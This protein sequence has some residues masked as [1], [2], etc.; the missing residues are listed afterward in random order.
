MF[1]GEKAA[2][3]KTLDAASAIA[4]ADV[5]PP[6]KLKKGQS[7]IPSY[8]STKS[9]DRSQSLDKSDR[10]V[11]TTDIARLPRFQG[12]DDLLR[13]LAHVSPDLSASMFAYIRTAVTRSYRCIARN[14]DG[15]VNPEATSLAQQLLVRYD[16]LPDYEAGFGGSLTVRSISESWAKELWINGACAGELVL[17]DD[18]MP[19]RV[20][21]LTVTTIEFKPDKEGLA[22]VQVVGGDEINLD[23]PTFFYTALD[24][25]LM[26]AYP[27]SPVE[28]ALRATFFSEQFIA[29]VQRV[30][31]RAIHPRMMVE[32]DYDAFLKHMPPEAQ[33]DP[34]EAE[35]YYAKTVSDI[36]DHINGLEPEDA[37]VY[38]NLIKIT[39]EVSGNISLARE[40]ETLE[41]LSNAKMATGAKVLPSVL[42]HN[43]GSSNI[44]ST[45][46][47]LFMKY[48]EGAIQF[49]L[50]EMWSKIM[51]LSCRLFGLDVYV[52]FKFDTIDLRPESELEAFKQ[53][54]Q[55]R[56]LELLS[57]GL[58]PDEEVA[59]ELTGNL[60]PEGHKPLSGTMFKS[61]KA[62]GENLYGGQTNKGSTLN[63]NLSP[64]TP[65]Q[66]RGENTK[67]NP[68]KE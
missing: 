28:S 67:S 22:P 40:Y 63:K 60:P 37:L 27:S 9:A 43:A 20:Q 30:V 15:T 1:G 57:L 46:T 10:R 25:E 58:M 50:N 38:A 21:P 12:T 65:S 3:G 29:D 64:D 11:A 62:Q 8:L 14:I 45:E 24:M 55:S 42:G 26:E 35:A 39:R 7:A 41:N 5:E 34:E 48:A 17:G 19:K 33:H 4:P 56:L 6:K 68:Q 47:M 31:R 53:A 16:Y 51:T 54:K 66:S 49:K 18:L 23:I 32:I 52:E 36:E 61:A 59:I 13:T 44:A 2:Q